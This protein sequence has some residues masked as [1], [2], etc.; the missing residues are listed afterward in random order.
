[1]KTTYTDRKINNARCALGL[2]PATFEALLGR[3]PDDLRAELTGR[4]LARV[5]EALNA[6]YLDGYTAAGG[7]TCDPVRHCNANGRALVERARS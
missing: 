4:Q 6:A 3:L 2:G 7:D 5:M 1:M